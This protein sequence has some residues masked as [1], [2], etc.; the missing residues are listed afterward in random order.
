AHRRAVVFVTVGLI[1]VE[2]LTYQNHA[3]LARFDAESPTPAYVTYLRAHLEG[4]RVLDAGRGA[5]YPE[6][7]SALGIPQVETLN[8]SQLPAYRRFFQQYIVPR[9]GLFLEVGA[10]RSR[11]F[12]VQPT[13]LDLLSV[14][15]IVTDGS[16]PRFDAGVR[17]RYPL[18][19]TDR[20]SGV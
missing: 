13:A 7:G 11:A 4:D 18:A 9:H 19:F 14:R 5:L 3:R 1:A 6:W 15:Y 16:M 12:N 8:V 10:Q 17:A 2:L 20:A